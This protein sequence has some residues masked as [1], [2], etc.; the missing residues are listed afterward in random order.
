MDSADF[1][2]PSTIVIRRLDNQTVTTP[3]G[4]FADCQ[5]FKITT[6]A[7]FDIKIA[8]I[9]VT[10]ERER[11]YHPKV[12]GLVKEVYRKG[13]IKFLAWSQEGYTATSVLTAFGKEEVPA[14]IRTTRKI[15]MT[16]QTKEQSNRIGR[17]AIGIVFLGATVTLVIGTYFLRNQVKRKNLYRKSYL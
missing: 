7:I 15:K 17:S 12:N 9:P 13:P 3:A 16:N 8:K 6:K 4:E 1:S 14:E 5:Y 2:L 10:E 11:W